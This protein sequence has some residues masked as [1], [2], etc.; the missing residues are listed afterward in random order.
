MKKL[1]EPST[2]AG[3]AAMFQMGAALAPQ[4]AFGFHCATVLAGT[5]AGLIGERGSQAPGA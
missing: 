4:Y 1:K 2:W 3:F 5:L